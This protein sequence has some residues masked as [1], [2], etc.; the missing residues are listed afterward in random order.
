MA[1]YT[2]SRLGQANATGSATALMQIVFAGEVLTA[3]ETATVLKGLT[4]NRTIDHGKSASFPLTWKATAQY[5][6][7]G[8]EINGGVIKHNEKLITIDG[9]CI[10]PVFV[11]DVDEAMNH[12]EVRSIYS[13]EMGRALALNYDRNI[14][15]S[16][17]LAARGAAQITGDASSAGGFLQVATG[18]TSATALAAGIIA[19]KQA[20]DIKDNPVDNGEASALVKTAQWYLLSQETTI[21]MNA[22]ANLSAGDYSKGILPLIGGV[23]VHK[24]NASVF[25]TTDAQTTADLGGIAAQAQYAGAWSNTVAAVFTEAAAGTVQLRGMSM[26]QERSARY[27]GTLL[28]GKYLTGHGPLL[29]RAAIEIGTGA[30]AG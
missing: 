8:V 9:L 11:A 17:L 3:F 4:R 20:L 10:A 7:P 21:L 19:A 12:F 13:K 18:L 25:G 28:V 30:V 29:H 26:E 5:H 15:R 27:Q 2:V 14:C 24:T 1:D 23:R 16:I 22:N 6:T